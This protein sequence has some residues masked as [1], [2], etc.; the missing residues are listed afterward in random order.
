MKIDVTRFSHAILRAP[1][2]SAVHGLRAV[3]RGDPDVAALEVEHKAYRETLETL[4]VTTTL[5]PALDDFPDSVFVEDP[6]L[7]FAEG[8]ILLQPGAPTRLGEVDEIAPALTKKFPRVVRIEGGFSDGGD[9]LVTPNAVVIGLSERTDLEGAEALKA[10][11]VDFGR[12]A[13]IVSPPQGILHFK[14]A[15]SM[16][17]PH[18]VLATRQLLSGGDYFSG[19]NIVEVPEGEEA[20]ANALAI[21]GTVLLAAGFPK[22]E[23]LLR[24]QGLDVRAL[25]LNEVMKLDAGLS[26]MSLRW[27][28]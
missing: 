16:V 9:V 2:Q 15:C 17:A 22:T 19:L 20:A 8:A 10:A 13:R 4:G 27:Q 11:L 18:T 5:L 7:V 21:N 6:A 12:E 24:E 3:D 14:T 25:Q 28:V 1:A 26:C 23:S